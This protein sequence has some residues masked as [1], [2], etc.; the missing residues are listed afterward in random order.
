[1][2]CNSIDEK[3]FWVVIVIHKFIA[4]NKMQWYK[5][6]CDNKIMIMFLKMNLFVTWLVVSFF[7]SCFKDNYGN[8]VKEM[9]NLH[10][11]WL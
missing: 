8:Y 7:Y 4:I 5:E 1:M 11:K 10:L 6:G 3:Y 9:N 2:V